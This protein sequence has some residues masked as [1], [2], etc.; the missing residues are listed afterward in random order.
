MALSLFATA[1][2]G[3]ERLLMA[4]V[5]TTFGTTELPSCEGVALSDPVAMAFSDD[6]R[7]GI[8]S[9]AAL[10]SSNPTWEYLSIVSVIVLCRASPCASFGDAPERTRLLM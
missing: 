2:N 4:G 8:A 1:D 6:G 10:R 5:S 9:R 7:Q 3:C